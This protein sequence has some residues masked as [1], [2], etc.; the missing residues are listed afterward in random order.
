M[1]PWHSSTYELDHVVPCCRWCNDWHTAGFPNLA[2]MHAMV[3]LTSSASENLSPSRWSDR[4]RAQNA[5]ISCDV[6]VRFAGWD[7]FG[8][9]P[10]A[11]DQLGVHIAAQ[12]HGFSSGPQLSEIRVDNGELLD[13]VSAGMTVDR[14]HFRL[15]RVSDDRLG[16]AVQI[17]SEQNQGRVVADDTMAGCLSLPRTPSPWCTNCASSYAGFC[18]VIVGSS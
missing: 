4:R 11:F 17:E 16:Q 13:K 12:V 14:L 2:E 5:W 9:A 18:D 1:P 10:Q 3:V 8:D 15:D 7:G 6:R